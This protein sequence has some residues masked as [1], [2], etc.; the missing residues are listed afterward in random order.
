[1]SF[2]PAPRVADVYE[3]HDRER[4]RLR[5]AVSPRMNPILS[6]EA[7]VAQTALL[8][9]N[10]T[11][12]HEENLDRLNRAR[13][14]LGLDT[15]PQPTATPEPAPAAP[16]ASA[17]PKTTL[18]PHQANTHP[19]Y[20]DHAG[21]ITSRARLTTLTK[22]TGFFRTA[23]GDTWRWV[24]SATYVDLLE[25][26]FAGAPVVATLFDRGDGF[27]VIQA[28][29]PA[30]RQDWD[31]DEFDFN[32]HAGLGQATVTH[33]QGMKKILAKQNGLICA[34]CDS[35]LGKH[36]QAT[37]AAEPLKPPVLMCRPCKEDWRDA[38]T[39]RTLKAVA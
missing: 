5:S 36:A 21:R 34:S 16:L 17:Q 29:R 1:M 2:V 37:I 28:V 32:E 19:T 33:R 13:T 22:T 10:L 18:P 39:P 30:T 31:T 7:A 4:L 9:E 27:V 26:L 24:A 3:S 25:E 35:N 23:T 20:T 15:V 11:R 38:Q 12:E 14:L 6:A 8:L